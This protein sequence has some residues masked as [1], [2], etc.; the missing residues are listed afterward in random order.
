MS[1]VFKPLPSLFLLFSLAKSSSC[2]SHTPAFSQGQV[3][4]LRSAAE[5]IIHVSQFFT[6]VGLC[7]T[8]SDGS[9]CSKCFGQSQ[10][11]YQ[12]HKYY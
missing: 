11:H 10:G 5:I 3:E 2:Q 12:G 6:W 8:N 4:I 7:K 9:C 1:S